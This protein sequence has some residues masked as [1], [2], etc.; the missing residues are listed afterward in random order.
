MTDYAIKKIGEL[1]KGARLAKSLTLD[2]VSAELKIRK[3]YLKEIEDGKITLKPDGY[4]VGYIN[5]YSAFLDVDV[6][7]LLSEFKR[8]SDDKYFQ[9][10]RVAANSNKLDSTLPTKKLVSCSAILLTFIYIL[11]EFFY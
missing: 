3:L 7:E 1:L 10:K 6:S 5:K 11:D 4:T 2:D 9:L 8:E